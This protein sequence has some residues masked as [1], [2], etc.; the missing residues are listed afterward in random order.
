M[1]TQTL[2]NQIA[3]KDFSKKTLRQLAAKNVQLYSALAVPAFEG[4]TCFSGVA[5]NLSYNGTGFIR[6][7]SQVIILAGSSWNP[8]TDL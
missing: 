4:D 5:Y 1:N 8:E 2:E 3:S 6:S 7:H